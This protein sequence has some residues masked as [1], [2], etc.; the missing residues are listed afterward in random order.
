MGKTKKTICI[1]TIVLLS[2]LTM[3]TTLVTF[4]YFS[5]KEIYD[6]YFS[7][8]V[9][10]LFDRLDGDGL[11]AY[12]GDTNAEITD[13]L[14]D[15][16]GSEEFPYVI[17]DVRHLY[18]LSELQR[19]GYFHKKYISRNTETDFTHIPYFLV[20]TPQY[21]PAL[22][23][24]T[25]FKGITSIGTDQYPFIGS[26]RGVK[27]TQAP[28]TVNGKTCDTSAIYNVKVS[29]NPA[30][31]DAGLF[32]H[33][34]FLGNS[35]AVDD[36][37]G[38]FSGQISTLSN[39]VL[40]D[41]QVTVQS[42]L[43]KTVTSFLEDIAINAT[44]GHRYS[45]TE[46]YNP[47]DMTDYNKVPHENH[48]I[49]ILAGHA[50]Y[51]KIEYISVYYSADDIVAIDLKDETKVGETE[52]NYLSAT[53]ILGF[54]DNLNPT[55][56][57]DGNGNL[58]VSAGSGDSVSD[59]SYG[60]AG[61]G[62][63]SSG[64]KP[65]YVLASEMYAK[66]RYT[67]T[68]EVIT[69]DDDGT[70]YLKD[71]V[72]KDGNAL[73]TEWIR[74]RILWGTEAT[75]R[76]Y[77]YDGVFTFALSSQEDVIEPT[78]NNGAADEFSIGSTDP[79][80]WEA[81]PMKGN[82][83][84][85]S[86]VKEISSL[87]DLNTVASSGQPIYIGYEQSDEQSDTVFL[88]SLTNSEEDSGFLNNFSDNKYKTYAFRKSFLIDQ[89]KISSIQQ[90]LGSIKNQDD[91]RLP[92][93]YDG[94][95]NTDIIENIRNYQLLN[96][97][98]SEDL[99]KLK[100]Q[101]T[102]NVTTANNGYT[103]Q[104]GN[105]KL[106]LLCRNGLLSG[107]TYSVW[108]GESKPTG[109][110]Y[111]SYEWQ[112]S[113]TVTYE[114]NSF[115]IRYDLTV[116]N[117]N[118]ATRYVSFNG[119]TSADNSRFQGTSDGTSAY[120]NL[121]F[122]TVEGTS[123]LNFGRVTFDPVDDTSDETDCYTF[124]AGET[125][126]FASSSHTNDA[127]GNISTTDT[128]YTVTPLNEL[129][130]N[131]G[132]GKTVSADDLQ[133]KFKMVKGITFG[134]SFNLLNGTLGSSGIITAPVGTNGTEANIPQSCIAFRIN[135]ANK[136]NKIRVIVSVAVSEF[137]PG[138]EGYD[139]GAYT[140]YFNLWKMEEAGQSAVQV[141]EATGENLL[142][143]FEVPRSHPYEPGKTAA[144]ADSEYITV[145]YNDSSYRCY[146]NGN[147]VL[148][149]YEFS[150]DT[151]AEGHGVG[152]FCLGM[153]GIG[154]DGQAVENVPM[155]IVYF[156]AEGVA[157]AGRDGASCSQ[158]GTIDFVYD[159]ES[160]IVTVTETSETDT[161]GNEVYS[162]YYPSYCIMYFNT[163]KHADTYTDASPVYIDVNFEHVKVRRYVLGEAE[164]PDSDEEHND[165]P[166]RS[167]I[168]AI[169]GGD[170]NTCIVQYSR[171]ADNVQIK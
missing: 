166:S 150:V 58:S 67:K 110:W 96:L 143:R 165:T 44:G 128:T 149:A 15:N 146:L 158:I 69:E 129:G 80:E 114:G 34:G 3:A 167:V 106:A 47:N 100:E 53:G 151:T 141:F 41:V 16:W 27:S 51:A 153:S 35:A 136:E 147:R 91:P 21:T 126:L 73:C 25:N 131:N 20:C 154:S 17:S 95:V 85:V 139:L 92:R 90:T 98:S 52:A 113:A 70:I 32:G 59:I 5:K 24:G 120:V 94:T 133:S 38:M 145:Q 68:D 50:A 79:S 12:T 127:N 101:Y 108:A 156:S 125:V 111:Q 65:G 170:K 19:L 45:F 87:A 140:R 86:F 60:T 10:L 105:S 162:N 171:Y 168:A 36:N 137:Y 159:Y 37:T 161:S 71:A 55:V 14:S 6:G 169:L 1:I 97:G 102:I 75:G 63:I 48:H 39:L 121:K 7:G 2:L 78:W 66:Y 88:M 109:N 142:D 81:K 116:N 82:E 135:N 46:L 49:G 119:D 124:N 33:I 43:W 83:S 138:E 155:E 118:S 30:N 31:A 130:W 8:E 93:K 56:A 76:Y 160:V 42:S 64:T 103:F 77:F 112:T 122:Y 132:S 11:K 26:V 23:N 115:I 40:V 22:I 62:G 134:A 89:N 29:G 54:I 117:S 163:A 99:N 164:T 123:D 18:N 84:V 107:Y 28:I 148:I 9:E 57:E 104:S 61:G 72:D 13:E 152:V 157:S 74:D 144:S 4:A